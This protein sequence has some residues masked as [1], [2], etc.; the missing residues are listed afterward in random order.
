[1]ISNSNL[2]AASPIAGLLGVRR[3]AGMVFRW[4]EG[5]LGPISSGVGWHLQKADKAAIAERVRLL[6]A[7]FVPIRTSVGPYAVEDE[8]LTLVGA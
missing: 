3:N 5:W 2:L 7:I 8:R 6:S 1:M 4:A